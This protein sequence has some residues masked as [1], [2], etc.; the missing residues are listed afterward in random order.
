MEYTLLAHASF[1]L[2]Q[3]ALLTKYKPT[4]D[5][6]GHLDTIIMLKMIR[7]SL[8]AIIGCVIALVYSMVASLLWP[9]HMVLIDL[10]PNLLGAQYAWVLAG[11]MWFVLKPLQD[12]ANVIKK[13]ITDGI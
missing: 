9:D 4:I 1:L 3:L 5:E 10:M 12:E 7:L 13:L 2:L 6:S 8:I 11:W